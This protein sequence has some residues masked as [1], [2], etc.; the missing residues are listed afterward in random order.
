M[1]VDY[2]KVW[3]SHGIKHPLEY[4]N[5]LY[6]VNYG[7]Y[8]P[9]KSMLYGNSIYPYSGDDVEGDNSFK[10]IFFKTCNSLMYCPILYPFANDSAFFWVAVLFVLFGFHKRDYRFRLLSY[11][12]ITGII[13]SL[14]CPTYVLNG[15]R[16]ALPVISVAYYLLFIGITVS[17]NTKPE[18]EAG[19]INPVKEGI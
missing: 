1:S 4:F 10:R 6:F 14:F 5:A 7:F 15:V 9:D 12:V 8:T 16:Y 18:K 17:K 19:M 11:P 2:L 3:S 13:I